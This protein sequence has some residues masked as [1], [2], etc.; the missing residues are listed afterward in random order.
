M[1]SPTGTALTSEIGS[2]GPAY[3]YRPPHEIYYLAAVLNPPRTRRPQTT[4][5]FR[6]SIRVN[7]LGVVNFLEGIH[8]A[9][10]G[11]RLF[12]AASSRIYGSESSG[13]QDETTPVNP[14]CVY[15]ITKAAGLFACRQYRVHHAVFASVGI[16]YNH[17][18][19]LR[20]DN[21]VSKKIVKAA[22]GIKQGLRD[23]LELGDLGM[24]ADWGYAPDYVEAM[25]RML[26]QNE[27]DDYIVATGEKHSVREFAKTAFSLLG[28]DWRRHVRENPALISRNTCKPAVGNLL[29]LMSKT[30]WRPP[31]DFIQMIRRLLE[32]EGAVIHG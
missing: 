5:L 15:G 3:W 1:D 25:H 24:E 29:K 9:S 22:L 23:G 32:A 16:L 26:A 11:T 14:S 12:Y 17:E 21:F 28:L 18:S 10:P 19:P 6:D 30:R 27:P 20:S 2:G 8:S 4:S 7:T 13:I 31:V